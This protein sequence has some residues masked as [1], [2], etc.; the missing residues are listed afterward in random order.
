[1]IFYTQVVDNVCLLIYNNFFFKKYIITWSVFILQIT[2]NSYYIPLRNNI[3]WHSWRHHHP[4]SIL[5]INGPLCLKKT[6]NNT[7]IINHLGINI[8]KSDSNEYN[9]AF[10]YGLLF[11]SNGSIMTSTKRKNSITCWSFPIDRILYNAGASPRELKRRPCHL[12]LPFQLS[13]FPFSGI[14]SPPRHLSYPLTIVIPHFFFLSLL[15]CFKIP[16]P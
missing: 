8:I 5:W 11:F 13:L 7:S 4:M 3:Q 12:S 15:G 10:L 14:S 1:M 9:S 16:F 6:F 2:N